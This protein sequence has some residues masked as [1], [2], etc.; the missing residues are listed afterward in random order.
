MAD[1][2]FLAADLCCRRIR[3]GES[4]WRRRWKQIRGPRICKR[5][6][7]IWFVPPLLG[8]GGGMRQR[9]RHVDGE[10]AVAEMVVASEIFATDAAKDDDRGGDGVKIAENVNIY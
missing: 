2:R 5:V 6:R 8:G 4:R 3:G 10:Y 9:R 7:P 1:R